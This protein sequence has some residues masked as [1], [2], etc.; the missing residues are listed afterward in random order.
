LG[1]TDK[2]VASKLETAEV[3]FI[4][5]Y[6]EGGDGDG[7]GIVDGLCVWWWCVGGWCMCVGAPLLLNNTLV[8][9]GNI[10]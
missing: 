2:V 7:D 8:S 1:G 4:F 6:P 10:Q 9:E 3:I 5:L